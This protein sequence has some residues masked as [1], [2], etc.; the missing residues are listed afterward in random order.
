MR[1]LIDSMADDNPNVRAVMLNALRN[2]HPSHLL[3][4]AV[5]EV[6]LDRPRDQARDQTP[7]GEGLVPL[8][9]ER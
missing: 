4:R 2:V 9:L 7:A 1:A 3:D 6:W 8:R 5:A